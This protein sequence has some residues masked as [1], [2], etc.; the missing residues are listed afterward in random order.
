MTKNEL[1]EFQNKIGYILVD[2]WKA[3]TMVNDLSGGY[4]GLSVDK[5]NEESHRLA[6]GYED[7][8]AKI[9]IAV[10]YLYKVEK[11][12]EDILNK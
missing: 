8:Q 1:L 10:D 5:A 4:F 6:C 11:A 7:G 12:L 9:S 3:R 2:L